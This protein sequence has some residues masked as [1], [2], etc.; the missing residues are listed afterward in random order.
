MPQSSVISC[1]ERPSASAIDRS[2]AAESAAPA[3]TSAALILP[4]V[5]ILFVDSDASRARNTMA[6]KAAGR[7]ARARSE[8]THEPGDNATRAIAKIDTT[9]VMPRTSGV[10]SLIISDTQRCLLRRLPALSV[11]NDQTFH[12]PTGRIPRL[13]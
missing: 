9:R 10:K 13:T 12:A 5:F 6:L 8:E 11:R 3:P 7:N 4:D 2:K 1:S